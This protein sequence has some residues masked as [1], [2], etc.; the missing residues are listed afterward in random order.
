MSSLG[1]SNGPGR[2]TTAGRRASSE[3]PA[4]DAV[5]IWIE[6]LALAL[7]AHGLPRMAGRIFGYLL[8]SDPAPR[9]AA[10]LTVGLSAS[11]GSISLMTK[12]LVHRGLIARLRQPGRRFDEY[13]VAPN[14]PAALIEA[15]LVWVRRLNHTAAAGLQLIA[16]QGPAARERLAR[17][18]AAS[19][20]LE[21]EVRSLLADL[22][23]GRQSADR[24]D[25]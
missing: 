24:R 22:V 20:S 18:V 12:L 14:A 4:E 2:Q 13:R 9:S 11:R 16:G 10:D 1:T 17:L 5:A 15:Q 7:Q 6:S 23:A 8:V 25:G 19:E 3:A 21:L